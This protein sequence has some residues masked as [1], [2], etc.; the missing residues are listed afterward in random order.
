PFDVNYIANGHS[1]YVPSLTNPDGFDPTT[2]TASVCNSNTPRIPATF[3]D[4]TSNTLLFA[5]KF[6]SNCNWTLAGTLTN[7]TSWIG[8]G[9]RSAPS[10]QNA[11]WAPAFAMESPWSDGTRFQIN[12]S[13][14]TCNVAYAQTG[15]TG[16]M[17]VALADGSA[18]SLSANISAG[19]FQNL[20]TPNGG[21]IIGPDF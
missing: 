8:G 21:E 4:G 13:S 6:A 15:H 10:V 17:V 2:T 12:P 3:Q 16:G 9:N 19:T 7:S 1:P 5:E 20:C 18:R 14:D 11:P